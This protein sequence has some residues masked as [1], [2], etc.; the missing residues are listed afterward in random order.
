MPAWLRAP[1]RPRG[2]Q[3]F[4]TASLASADTR[5]LN[6][7]KAARPKGRA[8]KTTGSSSKSLGEPRRLQ[9]K[10]QGLATLQRPLQLHLLGEL[11]TMATVGKASNL[12]DPLDI[13]S[14]TRP[15]ALQLLCEI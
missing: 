7:P 9:P 13:T 2:R 14:L 1:A 8:R 10:P 5:L 4:G 3:A 11:R 15:H 6:L 12:A